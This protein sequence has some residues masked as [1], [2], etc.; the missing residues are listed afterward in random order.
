MKQK[1]FI[2]LFPHIPLFHLIT[3]EISL[4]VGRIVKLVLITDS[5]SDKRDSEDVESTT[6]NTGRKRRRTTGNT[7][8][9]SA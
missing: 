9:S 4:S 8:G 7:Y 3:S 6:T 2:K 1:T 5:R